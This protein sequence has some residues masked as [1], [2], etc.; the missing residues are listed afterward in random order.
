MFT[1][2]KLSSKQ[3]NNSNEIRN[4]VNAKQ[5]NVANDFIPIRNKGSIEKTR[6]NTDESIIEKIW[7]S[8]ALNLQNLSLHLKNNDYRSLVYFQTCQSI[9]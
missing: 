3:A 1:K 5:L 8:N 9:R 7:R 2:Q 6:L 4:Q